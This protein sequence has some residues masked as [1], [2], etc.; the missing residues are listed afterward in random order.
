MVRFHDQFSRTGPKT[1]LRARRLLVG[2]GSY[3]NTFRRIHTY[4][5]GIAPSTCGRDE[6]AL[7]LRMPVAPRDPPAT[8]KRNSEL[9]SLLGKNTVIEKMVSAYCVSVMVFVSTVSTYR[10]FVT[11]RYYTVFT[12]HNDLPFFQSHICIGIPYGIEQ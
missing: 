2:F 1:V 3:Y 8:D 9:C 11:F 12:S 5:S 7:Q 4:T 6:R 10:V